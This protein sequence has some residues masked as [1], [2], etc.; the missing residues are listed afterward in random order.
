MKFFFGV[1]LLFFMLSFAKIEEASAAFKSIFSKVNSSQEEKNRI[2][3]LATSRLT[4]PSAPSNNPISKEHEA[5]DLHRSQPSV[6]KYSEQT[7]RAELWNRFK[8][9]NS[10]SAQ[11]ASSSRT[12]Q[13]HETEHKNQEYLGKR[14]NID[15]S[16]L[17]NKFKIKDRHSTQG[18]SSSRTLEDH[19]SQLQK[20]EYSKKGINTEVL[21]LKKK[22]KTRYEHPSQGS[23]S[24]STLPNNQIQHQEFQEEE[25]SEASQRLRKNPYTKEAREMTAKLAEAKHLYK[26]KIIDQSKL[27]QRHE[28]SSFLDRR[29]DF[30]NKVAGEDSVN[31]LHKY[32]PHDH[33]IVEPQLYIPS[34]KQTPTLH[35]IDNSITKSD[36]LRR[37]P[38]SR[39]N[40]MQKDVSDSHNQSSQLPQ[41]PETSYQ[42]VEPGLIYNH[43]G[44][45]NPFIENQV[46]SSDPYYQNRHHN[47]GPNIH[48]QMH[49]PNYDTNYTTNPYY[50]WDHHEDEGSG[51]RH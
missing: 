45:L 28:E 50:L 12:I 39:K 8:I 13:H 15:K 19:E 27:L 33:P 20:Q 3:A 36:N 24:T 29:V 17:W 11:S 6:R 2:D 5:L 18:D 43:N 31:L 16:G 7:Q 37:K 40:A 47:Y 48:H 14:G 22:I 35:E 42:N 38:R 32:Y 34:E 46:Y 21:D 10:H 25:Q 26:Q 1:P 30:R 44:T 51:S 4:T 41:L 9:K 23:S 49:D